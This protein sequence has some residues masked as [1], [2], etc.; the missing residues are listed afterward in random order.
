MSAR[1]ESFD[2][3]LA[4]SLLQGTIE[5]AIDQEGIQVEAFNGTVVLTGE[6]LQEADIKRA[7]YIA[8]AFAGQVVNLID[9]AAPRAGGPGRS[10][11]ACRTIG[12]ELEE[13]I[14]DRDVSVRVL[15]GKVI[16]EGTVDKAF[17]KERAERLASVYYPQVVS[18]ILVEEPPE[19]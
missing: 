2:Q 10:L 7:E 18:L 16:L 1:E 8:K 15:Q 14:G 11:L 5:R 9:L 4:D 19:A 17:R 6:A 12:P 13:A 3:S